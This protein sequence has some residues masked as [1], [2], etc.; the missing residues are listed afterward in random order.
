MVVTAAALL[1]CLTTLIFNSTEAFGNTSFPV[2]YQML[3]LIAGTLYIFLIALI[4]YHAG[5]LIWEERDSNNDEVQDALPVPEWPAF[6]AKFVALLCSIAI[7]LASGDGDG[8]PGA[9]LSSLLP[10]S[11][12]LVCRD[13]CS[14]STS[15]RSSFWPCWRFSSMCSRLTSTS[16]TSPSSAFAI[17]NLFIWRPLHVATYLVQF[18][19]TPNMVYSD[20]FGYAPFLRAWDGSRFTGRHFAWCWSWR[21][22]CCG[23]AAA[24]CVG[25]AGSGT[26]DC[27]STGR[28]ALSP[29]W[30]WS[31]SLPSGIWIY[32]NTKV[33]NALRSENDQ[34]TLQA[35]YEKTYKKFGKAAGA[36]HYRREICDRY[37]S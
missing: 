7:I 1:N 10:P 33:L 4:T 9:I 28:C 30:D 15:A 2:T 25:A 3:D 8:N 34:D 13:L 18:G 37:L 12:R 19:Q 16:A 36:A 11:D 21:R 26:R 23:R 35:D 22:W 27:V 17:V 14:G 31:H 24:T 29:Q 20:F 5:V 6:A 32:Y